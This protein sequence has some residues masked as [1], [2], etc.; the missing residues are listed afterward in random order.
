MP[1]KI[2]TPL[3][4][5]SQ[6]RDKKKPTNL[7][8]RQGQCYAVHG[9]RRRAH[10]ESKASSRAR[11]TENVGLHMRALDLYDLPHIS[12][13]GLRAL[14]TTRTSLVSGARLGKSI[15]AGLQSG[16]I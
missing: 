4:T 3:R 15:L 6:V 9:L 13:A 12:V 11:S 14:S 10:P 1:P 8:G 2:P 7:E 5:K 16:R